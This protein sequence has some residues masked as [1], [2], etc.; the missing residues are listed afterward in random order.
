MLFIG[1]IA[2]INNTT[3]SLSTDLYIH[4]EKVETLD[5]EPMELRW[6]EI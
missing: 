6:V 1:K 5:L 4:G 3:D 2:V